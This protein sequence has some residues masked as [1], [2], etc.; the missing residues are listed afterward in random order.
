ME[1]AREGAEGVRMSVE[2]F[3][4]N[5]K[6]GKSEFNV[7]TA[8]FYSDLLT[9]QDGGERGFLILRQ[10]EILKKCTDGCGYG[11]CTCVCNISICACLPSCTCIR[12]LLQHTYNTHA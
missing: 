4:R 7:P 6:A 12:L 8:L 10:W 2:A 1:A 11:V 5:C 9:R 3:C